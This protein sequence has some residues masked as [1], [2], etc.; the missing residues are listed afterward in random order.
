MSISLEKKS[1]SQDLKIHST[2][3]IK[4]DFKIGMSINP[5]TKENNI[6]IP[7]DMSTKLIVTGVVKFPNDTEILYT[8]TTLNCTGLS[9]IDFEK[10][11]IFELPDP[12]KKDV[13]IKKKILI[14]NMNCKDENMMHKLKY[15]NSI[16]NL[17]HS[18]DKKENTLLELVWNNN[19][20]IALTNL[21]TMIY[22]PIKYENI[23]LKDKQ[24][25][26]F[27][28]MIVVW[29][30]ISVNVYK[31][32]DDKN[33]TLLRNL[34]IVNV[35]K[36][37]L[38]KTGLLVFTDKLYYIQYKN[39]II[40]PFYRSTIEN[41]YKGIVLDLSLEEF[42]SSNNDRTQLIFNRAGKILYV[43][44]FKLNEDLDYEPIFNPIVKFDDITAT[45][46]EC[47]DNDAIAYVETK[48][49][50]IYSI[51]KNKNEII[52]LDNSN[53]EIAKISIYNSNIYIFLQDVSETIIKLY[54]YNTNDLTQEKSYQL[55]L[56]NVDNQLAVGKI[57][58]DG[59]HL[60]VDEDYPS[61]IENII[62]D[63]HIICS[64]NNSFSIFTLNND[65]YNVSYE[66]Q[67]KYLC[68]NKDGTL[69]YS[70][71]DKLYKLNLNN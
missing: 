15:S 36:C 26:I 67:Y 27:E 18:K 54:V 42:N 49:K 47:V 19:Q 6:T 41:M 4:P 48:N 35:E 43:V 17:H 9:V 25:D 22:K 70:Y 71:E 39:N 5:E 40:E 33:I 23:D 58:N 29:D 59:Q 65:Q 53:L 38:L 8:Q 11:A 52:Q 45:R 56:Y 2:S 14:S 37:I 12:D 31:F 50:K 20:W 13:E 66:Y 68:N 64:D 44:G 1:T 60:I 32:T 28:S 51:I 21:N 61:T 7:I 55:N 3:T 69:Y 24:F 57:I 63:K 46:L 16:V 34:E 30:K 10:S 62:N